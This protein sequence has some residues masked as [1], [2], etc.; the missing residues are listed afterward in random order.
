M[1]LLAIYRRSAP[2]VGRAP[3]P[4]VPTLIFSG[5]DD[6]R[7]PTA[8]ARQVAAQIPDAHLL[9][10]PNT[11]H[12][13]LGIGPHRPAPSHALQAL[14]AGKPVRKCTRTQPAAALLPDS[15][16]RRC[17]LAKCRPRVATTVRRDARSR[18]SC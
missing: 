16:R 17:S 7:T 2:E 8:N 15:A 5:A 14:F 10:V 3:L 4:N 18:R 12:S 11:G 6:L 9:V 13:V 1:R